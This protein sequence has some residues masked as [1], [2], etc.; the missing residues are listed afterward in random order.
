LTCII[1]FNNFIG[2]EDQRFKNP[3]EMVKRSLILSLLFLSVL[4]PLFCQISP[5]TAKKAKPKKTAE[6]L[7]LF[8]S[9]ELLEVTLKFDLTGFMRKTKSE[10]SFD[11]EMNIYNGANDSVNRKIV[12][13]HRGFFRYDNCSFPPVEINLKKALYASG[14]SGRIKK[15]KLVNHCQPGNAYDEYIL[16]EYLVYKMF[17]IIT[18]TSFRVRLLRVTY[19]DTRKN[20]KPIIQ[21]GFFVEPKNVLAERINAIALNSMNLNQKYIVPVV[22]DRIAIFSYMIAHWDWSVPGQHNMLLLKS[23]KIN[24]SDLGLAV[25]FDFDLTGVVNAEYAVPSEAL[26]LK[27]IR[28]RRFLG[29]CLGREEF[30]TRLKEFA[31][32]KETIY[33]TVTDFPYL[34]QKSKNDITAFLDQFFDQLEK[35]KSF[36]NLVEYF[37]SNCKNL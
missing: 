32:K 16:R 20:R 4:M 36:I 31:A 18:D 23:L 19:I 13:K 17:N 26:G 25:P 7:A 30:Q 2:G 24:T 35:P 28:E 5:D 33:K 29:I 11:G 27:T 14:D 3:V 15:L 34:S 21:Y 10:D 1:D 12:V 9:D 22:I 8:G 37:V 6:N